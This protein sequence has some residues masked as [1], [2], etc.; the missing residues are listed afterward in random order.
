VCGS[1]TFDLI[2]KEILSLSGMWSPSRFWYAH[3]IA[4]KK[5]FWCNGLLGLCCGC[6]KG[7]EVKAVLNQGHYETPEV[8]NEPWRAYEW[9]DDGHKLML[10]TGGMV[11][12]KPIHRNEI[13]TKCIKEVPQVDGSE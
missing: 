1:A 6:E 12:V 4:H 7:Q 13:F 5:V 8:F 3:T 10:V 9:I 2:T 11:E